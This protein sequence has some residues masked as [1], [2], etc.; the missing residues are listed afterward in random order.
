MTPKHQALIDT[1]LLQV[2][3]P[4]EPVPC[5]LYC[6]RPACALVSVPSLA[7]G[8]SLRRIAVKRQGEEKAGSIVIGR[9]KGEFS[10]MGQCNLRRQIESQA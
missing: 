6:L 7:A 5:S 9:V 8:S 10:S 3:S 4:A 1:V 2:H